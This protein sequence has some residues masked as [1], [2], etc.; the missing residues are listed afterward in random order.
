MGQRCFGF[1]N[2]EVQIH[3]RTR[4][5]YINNFCAPFLNYMQAAR[6]AARTSGSRGSTKASW[7]TP[8][9]NP[10]RERGLRPSAPPIN[11]AVGEVGG[12]ETLLGSRG[13]YLAMASKRIAQSSALRPSGPTWSNVQL[14]G[15]TP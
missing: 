11:V 6:Q 8:S 9:L 5:L 14:R 12:P 7:G 1:L 10:C 15:I 2:G 13:S 3:R 4:Q